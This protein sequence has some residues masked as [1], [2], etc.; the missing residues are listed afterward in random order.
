VYKNDNVEEEIN[1]EPSLR[2]EEPIDITGFPPVVASHKCPDRSDRYKFVSS[3]DIV[4]A[5]SWHGWYPSKVVQVKVRTPYREGYQ[6]HT[7]RFRQSNGKSLVPNEIVFPEIIL[8]NSHDGSSPVIFLV[9]LWR[10]ICANGLVT[11]ESSISYRYLHRGDVNS[12]IKNTITYIVAKFPALAK[13]IET[14]DAIDLTPEERGAYVAS[15]LSLKYDF[16]EL[17]KKNKTVDPVSLLVPRRR[18]D[19]GDSL[20]KVFNVVQEKLTKGGRFLI[21]TDKEGREVSGKARGIMDIS[22][23]IRL[24][25]S[26]WILTEQMAKLKGVQ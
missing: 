2:F 24:N 23:D 20:W 19:E 13:Y 26:L 18:Q 6:K 25:R 7:I 5:F 21:R 4:D 16:S 8:V 22:E 17:M 11:S 3:S 10:Q 1:K 9:G 12:F 14:L 15:A